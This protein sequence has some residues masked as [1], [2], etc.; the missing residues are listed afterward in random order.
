MAGS[1]TKHP[2]CILQV[3]IP[4]FFLSCS[5]TALPGPRPPQSWG[6]EITLRH[7]TPHE[8][9]ARR[10]DLYLTPHKIHNRQTSMTPAAF[11]PAIP[12]SEWAQTYALDRGS[13]VYLCYLY[14]YCI[15][16]C[17]GHW[18]HIVREIYTLH[19]GHISCSLSFTHI[20]THTH[21]HAYTLVSVLVNIK[22]FE[23]VF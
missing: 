10:R 5:P 4:V 8:G 3:R 16:H 2:Q 11:E 14:I 1:S 9:S 21:T 22:Q 17:F 13:V 7:N 19:S 15:L 18:M 23:L 6:L 12:A 20:H